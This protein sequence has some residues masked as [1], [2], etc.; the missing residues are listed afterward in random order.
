MVVQGSNKLK[1]EGY[2]CTSTQYLRD[3]TLIYFSIEISHIST[4]PQT[5]LNSRIN[6]IGYNITNPGPYANCNPFK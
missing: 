6:A 1:I 5:S 2:A 4:I 3:K